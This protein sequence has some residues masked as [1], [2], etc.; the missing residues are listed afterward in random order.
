MKIVIEATETASTA[1]KEARDEARVQ[2]DKVVSERLGELSV[3]PNR[4]TVEELQPLKATVAS[5]KADGKVTLEE[6][7][8]ILVEMERVAALRPPTRR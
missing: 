6:A 3:G 1:F 8:R 4:L 7:D 5:A 2:R